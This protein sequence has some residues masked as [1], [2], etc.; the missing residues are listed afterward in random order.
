MRVIIISFC[1]ILVACVK[2]RSDPK[3]T[4]VF[5]D[6]ENL[7]ALLYG[8]WKLYEETSSPAH[9]WN[10]DGQ[11]ETDIFSTYDSCR[12]EGGFQFQP[13]GR[14]K[15]LKTCTDAQTINWKVINESNGFTFTTE[16]NGV[17]VDEKTYRIIQLNANIFI[18]TTSVTMP[19]GQHYQVTSRYFKR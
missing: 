5:D 10:G 14:G 12:R 17:I 13:N 8:N 18:I 11:V 15:S 16:V 1:I 3:P 9:D 2:Y 6:P 4:A 19:N 7:S